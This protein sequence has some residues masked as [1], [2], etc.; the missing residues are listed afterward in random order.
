M[1]YESD[2]MKGSLCTKC[3]NR[4]SIITDVNM[5][6]AIAEIFDIDEFIDGEEYEIELNIC[7]ETG[8]DIIGKV[9]KC[10]K[11]KNSLSLLASLENMV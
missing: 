1:D 2:S 7:K 5:N 3:N 10:N 11:F 6:D 8:A 9:R 4:I